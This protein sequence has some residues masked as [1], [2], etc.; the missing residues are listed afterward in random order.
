MACERGTPATS[1]SDYLF[2]WTAAADTSAPD[3]LAVYDIRDDQSSANY[4][5]LITTLPVPG[6]GHR[7][8]HT[9]HELAADGQLFAN[10]YGTGQSFI[11]D[12]SSPTEPRLVKEFSEANGLMHAHSFMR[13]P[14]GNVLTTFQMQHDSAG[15]AP[16]GLAEF[17]PVGQVVRAASA[18]V[19]GVD[20]RIRP[21]SAAILPE[22]D[23]VVVTTTDM[24]NRDTISV[25]Q[26]WR[27][28]DLSL[29]HT[30]QLPAG[31]RGDEQYRSAEPRLLDDGRV[32]VSTFNCGLYLLEGVGEASPSAKLV[33]SFPRKPATYCAVPVIVGKYYLVT[34][35]VWS[36]VVSL[37]IS[38]PTQPREVSR[39]TLGEDDVPHWIAIE[40]NRKRLVIT[41][42]AGM[43]HRVVMA[44][45]DETNGELSLDER[46]RMPGST[47]SGIRMDGVTWPHG[48]SIAGI[49]HGAVFSRPQK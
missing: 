24:D 10:G 31:P 6:R 30:I 29:Q 37:D 34:V 15:I 18:N 39:L 22:A 14:N 19:N 20:R 40:P 5:K 42:Y 11:F 46:F 47:T 48:G 23:R 26:I 38:D 27:L 3:F 17:T 25:L 41:G 33:A 8:H 7:T 9:E 1:S 2:L 36:A 28:S 4:G 13:L 35:P 49:P 43:K 12:L 32:L 44:R 21:Y 16:G 45:F